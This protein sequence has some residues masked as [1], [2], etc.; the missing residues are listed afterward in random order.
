MGGMDTVLQIV[1]TRVEE[2]MLTIRLSN[3][4]SINI[5][6]CPWGMS[7]ARF[8]LLPSSV[9]TKRSPLIMSWYATF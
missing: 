1:T 2:T 8:Q 9:D 6:T 3:G 5:A 4:C 7:S